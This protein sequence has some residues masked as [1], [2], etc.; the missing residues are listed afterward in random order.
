MSLVL[1]TY[2]ILELFQGSEKGKKVKKLLEKE[3][4]V[5]L[6]VLSIYELG[7]VLEREIGRKKSQ[8]YLRSV[9]T[10]YTILDVTYEVAK[11]AVEVRRNFKLPAI[12]CLIYASAFINESKVVSGCKHFREISH[13]KNVIVI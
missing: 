13:Q 1:D 12:D 2:A 4:E 8:E 3:E 9:E 6:S 7:T 5:Y 10:Y 11:K